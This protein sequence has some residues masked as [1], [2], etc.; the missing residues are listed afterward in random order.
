MVRVGTSS[1][2]TEQNEHSQDS[3]G[4]LRDVPDILRPDIENEFDPTDYL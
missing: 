2:E 4:Y 1:G 3:S